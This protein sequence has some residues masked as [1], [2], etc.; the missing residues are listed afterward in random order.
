MRKGLQEELLRE[1]LCDWCIGRYYRLASKGTLEAAKANRNSCIVCRGAAFYDYRQML[2]KEL[3]R[4]TF[5]T[6]NIG[7]RVSDKALVTEE[8]IVLKYGIKNY[9]PLK[10]ALRSKIMEEMKDVIPG[11][12]ARER[13]EVNFIFD[14]S[15]SPRVKVA[16]RSYQICVW[17]RKDESVRLTA[18]TCPHCNGRGCSY[19][20]WIGK[21]N[22]GS[23]ESFLLF[24][25]PR[26]YGTGT[27]T[28]TLPFKE[29]PGLKISGTGIPVYM[30]FSSVSDRVYMPLKLSFKPIDGVEITQA[31]TLSSKSEYTRRYFLT[32]YVELLLTEAPSNKVV[33]SLYSISQVR[34]FGER[35]RV[36]AKSLKVSR[37]ELTGNKIRL[38][39][40]I[41]SGISLYS[42]LGLPSEN[43]IKK[44]E[45]PL[46]PDGLAKSITHLEL[47]RLV[48]A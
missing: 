22:D 16:E 41:E 21:E 3:E 36:W 33:N 8:N 40:T 4:R 5:R 30:S 6:Y 28:I 27:P 1:G 9:T 18:P 20:D 19:C 44:V 10:Q 13:P 35:G 24:V 15:D 7:V 31:Y 14:F 2:S 11:S 43:S 46:L 26:L 25:F 48:E 32:F 23:L 12:P 45:R 38:V 37:V 47:L 39:L 42:L 17:I 29:I 34:L